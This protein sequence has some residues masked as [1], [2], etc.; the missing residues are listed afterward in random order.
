MIQPNE[1]RVRV[2]FAP[3]SVARAGDAILT[4]HDIVPPLGVVLIG[5]DRAAGLAGHGVACS[6]CARPV[7]ARAL[8]A[9]YVGRVRSGHPQFARLVVDLPEAGER[10]VREAIATDMFVSGRYV[11]A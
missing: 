8:A 11:A 6:C 9:A 10:A 2:V 5:L 4:D 1:S 3:A 7:L